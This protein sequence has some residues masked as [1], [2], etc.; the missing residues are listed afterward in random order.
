MLKMTGHLDRLIRQARAAGDEAA[1]A[2]YEFCKPSPASNP[3]DNE[4]DDDQQ[5]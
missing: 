5:A 1:E 2:F 3:D 4:R